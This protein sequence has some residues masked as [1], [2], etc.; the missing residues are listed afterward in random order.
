MSRPF[1][2]LKLRIVI[3][4]CFIFLHDKYKKYNKEGSSVLFYKNDNLD[5]FFSFDNS[6]KVNKICSRVADLLAKT[7]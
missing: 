7:S 6:F 3:L 4:R 2:H 5:D 1:H